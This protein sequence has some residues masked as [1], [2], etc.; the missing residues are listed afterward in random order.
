MKARAFGQGYPTRKRRK[1]RR[2]RDM[3]YIA[4]DCRKKCTYT[5]VDQVKWEGKIVHDAEP[6][7]RFSKNVIP[8]AQ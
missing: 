1:K 3:E 5:V 6:W 7:S 8:E 4:F 2:A